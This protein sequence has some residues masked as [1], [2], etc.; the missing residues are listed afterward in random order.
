MYRRFLAALA[1]LLALALLA[2]PNRADDKKDAKDSK[3]KKDTGVG[4]AHIKLAG[5]PTEAPGGADNPLSGPSETF[6]AKLDRIVKAKTDK[7]V[8]ALFLEIDGISGGWGKMNE[9]RTA[10]ADF[11]SGGK[12]AYAYLE[13]GATMDYLVAIA[14]D[15]VVMPEGGTI[16]MAGL[17]YELSFYKDLLDM[18]GLKAEVVRVGSF[19]GA[20]EPFTRN[21]ISPEN[22]KQWEEMA[23]DNFA[24]LLELIAK[25]RKGY[26]VE[27]ARKVIDRGP[28]TAR[29][30]KELGLIDRIAYADDFQ[31]AM[32]KD[33][34]AE[35]LSIKKDYGK[36]KAE[37]V[38]FSNPFA[39]LKM[40]SPPKE[41]KVSDK[42]KVAVIFATGS[43]VTGK[44]GF[45]LT[46]GQS[47]GSTTL[48]EAIKKAEE[49]P[50]VKAI[51]LRVDSPGGSALASDL[52]WDALIRCKKPVVAS[53][54]DVAASGGYYIS[55]AAKKIYAEPGTI[56]GSIGVFGL[57]LVM[58]GLYE[59]VGLKTE[60]ISR[61]KNAGIMSSTT[62]YSPSEREAMEEHVKDIY[63]TFV[64]KAF[65]GRQKAGNDKLKSKEE[66]EKLAGGRIWTGRQAKANGLIDEL[67][68]L[69][70]AIASAKE[71]AGLA[72]GTETELYLLPKNKGL[73][74]LES[75][76]EGAD[77]AAQLPK[78]LNL[79]VLG[80]TPEMTRHLQSVEFLIRAR[81]DHTW[82]LLP[83]RIEQK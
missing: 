71:M 42:P 76:L 56:T 41:A 34:Q 11:R 70:D 22:R 75:F 4:I 65:Q 73:G 18:V 25:S 37:D 45:S 62:P 48:I 24:Q 40:L 53:M 14:C 36:K 77:S 54:G 51:V 6:K 35:K 79:G 59:K 61:G 17:R 16:M 66:L 64:G 58:G 43:I 20:V 72:K 46:G 57:K 21:S 81:G 49:E 55:M 7:D 38:D 28:F 83:Y 19:K 30:A 32:K 69:E 12:K 39:L 13:D 26:D 63:A 44:S 9:L 1:A 80:L 82:A 8:K 2:G 27:K 78:G 5:D 15:E 68:T 47:V 23:D 31:E 10:I 52:I 67:G 29:K 50:T 74:I 33:L 3:A 60:V